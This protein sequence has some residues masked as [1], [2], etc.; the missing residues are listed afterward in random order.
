MRCDRQWSNKL[1]V[2]LRL[3]KAGF[4][5]SGE[6]LCPAD[7][8]SPAPLFSCFTA[9]RRKDPKYFSVDSRN[10][11][12]VASRASRAVAVLTGQLSRFVVNHP[13]TSLTIFWLRSWLTALLKSNLQHRAPGEPSAEEGKVGHS[14]PGAGYAGSGFFL[15]SYKKAT[16]ARTTAYHWSLISDQVNNS[17]GRLA[18]MARNFS[19]PNTSRV[20]RFFVPSPATSPTN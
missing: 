5:W 4:E 2:I 3:R 7:G 9:S 12:D 17:T 8:P 10:V 1:T 6:V 20:E 14:S 15:V 11:V 18:V 16:V 19:A 13:T